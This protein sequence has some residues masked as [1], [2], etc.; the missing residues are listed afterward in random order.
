[1]KCLHS[2]QGFYLKARGT[3]CKM[4]IMSLPQL[5]SKVSPLAYRFPEP[6]SRIPAIR[7][8]AQ[9]VVFSRS[10]AKGLAREGRQAARMRPWGGE[11]GWEVSS[12]SLSI[13]YIYI[14]IYIYVR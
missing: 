14:Y 7:M 3:W 9:R 6:S 11:Q 13:F 1:M 10:A 8:A 4:V 2:G 5:S 12:L